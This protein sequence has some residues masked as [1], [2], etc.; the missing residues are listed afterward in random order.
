MFMVQIFFYWSD[1]EGL[2][3]EIA[4]HVQLYVVNSKSHKHVQCRGVEQGETKL[5]VNVIY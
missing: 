3:T 4:F 5:A 2:E 1:V